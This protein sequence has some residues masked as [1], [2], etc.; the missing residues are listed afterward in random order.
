MT[1]I[2]KYLLKGSR[3]DYL[4]IGDLLHRVCLL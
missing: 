1:N 4:R 3:F 2:Q